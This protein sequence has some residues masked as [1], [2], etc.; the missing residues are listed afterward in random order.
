MYHFIYVCCFFF[1]SS[2]RRHTRLQGDWSSDVC[3]SDLGVLRG[4][5][6]HSWDRRPSSWRYFLTAFTAASAS[7]YPAPTSHT[8][9]PGRGRAVC[10]RTDAIRSG[11]RLPPAASCI[12]ATTPATCGVAIDVPD[13][14][15]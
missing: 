3:S 6:G 5:F 14:Q 12:S 15:V 11:V 7:T 9:N 8:A 10:V 2:R 13:A 4:G 1:F